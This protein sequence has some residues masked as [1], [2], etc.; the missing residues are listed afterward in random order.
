MFCQQIFNI[1][2]V[3]CLLNCVIDCHQKLSCVS[4]SQFK[5]IAFQSGIYI[6]DRGAISLNTAILI[7][8]RNTC[9][10]FV[11]KE[12]MCY[13]FPVSVFLTI[14]PHSFIKCS[15]SR[16]CRRIKSHVS[17]RGT[18]FGYACSVIISAVCVFH[19][20]HNLIR[21]IRIGRPVGI[22]IRSLCRDSIEIEH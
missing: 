18:G 4:F 1:R 17:A 2:Q 11:I 5:L 9:R 20:Q 12:D 22:D 19:P 16:I 21:R 14:D 13:I 15:G 8:F 6:Q 7:D 3:V 10:V